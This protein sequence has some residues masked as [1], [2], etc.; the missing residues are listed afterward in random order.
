MGEVKSSNLLFL[1]VKA[2]LKNTDFSQKEKLIKPLM[3]KT[4]LGGA[5]WGREESIR[6]GKIKNF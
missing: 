2:N 1:F 6:A 5:G 4:R 3:G